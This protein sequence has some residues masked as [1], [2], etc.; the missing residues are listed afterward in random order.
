MCS[1]IGRLDR[2]LRLTDSGDISTFLV[3]DGGVIDITTDI[4]PTTRG[5]AFDFGDYE[6]QSA[7]ALIDRA[8]EIQPIM[9]ELQR[10][11][12]SFRNKKLDEFSEEGDADAYA[13]EWPEYADE[14]MTGDWVLQLS[15]KEFK[16]L[17][18]QMEKWAE[19]EPDWI[20]EEADYFVVSASGQ[21]YAF[22]F[23]RD[24]DDQ[25]ALNE[26]GVEVVEGDRPGSTYFAAELS[27]P[28]EEANTKAEKAGI[29]IRFVAEEE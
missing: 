17:C 7:D 25:E 10:Q 8:N 19:T 2:R 13:K 21:D 5:E 3:R 9:W 20:N 4:A 28:V 24:Y 27:I 26:L 12:E 22:T 11:Y 29:P 16:E 15:I 23:F 6:L 1:I 18:S 14:E